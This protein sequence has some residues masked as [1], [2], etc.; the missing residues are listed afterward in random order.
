VKFAGIAVTAGAYGAWA[1]IGFE[2]I[3]GGYEVAWKSS[4]AI[5]TR[6]EYRQ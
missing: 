4:G 6:S 2:Q 5:F 1:P 3:A